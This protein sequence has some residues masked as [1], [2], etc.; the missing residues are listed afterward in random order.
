M[1]MTITIPTR[2]PLP[3]DDP[4]PGAVTVNWRG[5]LIPGDWLIRSYALAQAVLK[6]DG[7]TYEQ[8]P[9]FQGAGVFQHPETVMILAPPEPHRQRRTEVQGPHFGRERIEGYAAGVIRRRAAEAAAQL[10]AAGGG[11]LAMIALDYAWS[12]GSEVIGIDNLSGEQVRRRF[13]QAQPRAAGKPPDPEAIRK[14]FAEL[15]DE[16]EPSLVRRREHPR[17]DLFST[18]AASGRP[19]ELLREEAIL[20]LI[21]SFLTTSGA[22]PRAAWHLSQH[23]EYRSLDHDALGAAFDEALRLTPLV[24]FLTRRATQ[25][26]PLG[27]FTI[28]A[29]EVAVIDI[30]AANRDP[31]VFGEDAGEFLPG[32]ATQGKAL[33]P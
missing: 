3:V 19:L 10:R 21:A 7:R 6:A 31:A 1:T 9:L 26:Q 8:G 11:D 14:L 2:P 12:V 29:G 15:M 25:D 17:D 16:V 22:I 33:R 13:F 23:A 20:W 4:T 18:L 30:N 28:K 5:P 27:I 24:P 32:R